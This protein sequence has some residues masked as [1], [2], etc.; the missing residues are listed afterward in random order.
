M[1]VCLWVCLFVGLLPQCVKSA[2]ITVHQTGFV[3][4]GS[5]HL[6]LIKFWPSCAPRK[7]SAVGRNFWLCHYLHLQTQF[8][9]DRCMH[10]ASAQCLHLFERLFHFHC[11]VFCLTGVGTGTLLI[12]CDESEDVTRKPDVVQVCNMDYFT[13][14]TPCHSVPTSSVGK[15]CWSCMIYDS[16][17]QRST[18]YPDIYH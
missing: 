1:F 10:L 18:V 3:G 5:D 12:K 9:E 2:C 4:E 11:F 7:G 15:R 6:Q 8:G 14:F 16:H 13:V 17:K